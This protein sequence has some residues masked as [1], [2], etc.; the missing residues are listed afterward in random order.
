MG[1]RFRVEVFEGPRE[2]AQN[3]ASRRPHQ[4][5]SIVA[6]L[7]ALRSSLAAQTAQPTA[8][9][10]VSLESSIAMWSGVDDIQKRLAVTKNEIGQLQAKGVGTGEASRTT[11]ELRAVV[12]GTEEATDQIL[13]AA[14]T[15]D[16]VCQTMIASSDGKV[17]ADGQAI[18]DAVLQIFEACNFQDITGQR[19]TK[20][21]DS[22]GFIEERIAS[23]IDVW[24]AIR[25][26]Q[27]EKQEAPKA[28]E[29][30]AERDKALLNGPS[31]K[32][33]PGV[34]SQD[35]VDAMFP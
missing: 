10:A 11:D 27:M 7:L 35:D 6:E 34:V 26:T 23:M 21:V 30:E 25:A 3:A 14:E 15:I 1:R 28:P 22:L 19:I 12:T 8:A 29:T 16:N 13:A 5:D 9:P 2:R 31:L 32:D 17:Q 33:D 24:E 4:A 18:A 20:V